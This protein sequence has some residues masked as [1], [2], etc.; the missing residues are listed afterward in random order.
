M[1]TA[2]LTRTISSR[3]IKRE[4][5]LID[6]KGKVLGR[7]VTKIAS[8]L[9]GKNKADYSPNHDMGDCVVVINARHIKVTGR[10]EDQKVYTRYSGYPSGLAEIPFSDM[11]A[12]RPT[13]IVRLAVW[14][15]LPKNKLRKPRITRLFI[16]PDGSHKHND[17]FINNGRK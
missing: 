4:W 7:V 2:K 12:K 10:K 11:K 16:Y 13:E 1:K 8:L 3:E 17:K 6:V 14:G 9:I 5:H 15:M